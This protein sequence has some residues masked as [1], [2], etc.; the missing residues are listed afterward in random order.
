MVDSMGGKAGLVVGIVLAVTI[1][2][3][4]LQPI[5]GVVADNTGN[6][7]V[8]NE[9]IVANH[10]EYVD[11][12]GYDVDDSETVQSY[13]ATPTV[14]SEGS[15]YEIALDNGS[16]KALSSGTI[17]DGEKLNVTYSYQATSGAATTVIGF[18]PVMVGLLLF[19]GAASGVQRQM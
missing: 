18:V 12:G 6:V 5:V 14:Y 8:V 13:E 9:T 19:V 16:V 4:V 3:V 17:T 10:G 2:I 7:Q 15:D 11:L 1:G